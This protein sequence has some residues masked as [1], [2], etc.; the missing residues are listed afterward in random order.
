MNQRAATGL[1]N[2][3]VGERTSLFGT[4]HSRETAVSPVS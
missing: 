1:K 4:Y 2:S 3:L